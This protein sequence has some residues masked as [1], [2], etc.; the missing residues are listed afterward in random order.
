MTEVGGDAATHIDISIRLITKRR[1][2]RLSQLLNHA[3]D[4]SP[5]TPFSAT[6]MIRGYLEIYE[7]AISGSAAVPASALTLRRA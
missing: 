6:S 7:Q 3:R 1:L 2:W 5:R 4:A